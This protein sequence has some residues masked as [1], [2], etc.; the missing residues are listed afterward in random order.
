MKTRDTDIIKCNL[1]FHTILAIKD[2]TSL[3]PNAGLLA[4]SFLSSIP[5]IVGVVANIGS[6]ADTRRK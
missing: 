1:D 2:M 5:R 6:L 3:H 4:E